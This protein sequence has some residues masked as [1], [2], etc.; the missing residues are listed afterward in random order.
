[1]ER[2]VNLILGSL[3]GLDLVLTVWGFL[4]PRLW[5][6]FFHGAD[7]I[8]PQAL[9]YRCAANWL[10]FLVL[11]VIALWRWRRDPMWL[12]VVAGCRLGDALTD[13]TCLAL[14]NHTTV[15]ARLAFPAAGVGN[16][17]IG[18][19]LLRAYRSRRSLSAL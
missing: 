17:I 10:A 5:Y 14:A 4:L 19:A 12:A 7:Y 13:V 1:M 15:F 2:R 3:I 9:L 16:L 6:S 11:Q 8:D 18:V